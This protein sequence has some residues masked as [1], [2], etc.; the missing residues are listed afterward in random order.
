MNSLTCT[1][2]VCHTRT[3]R[4]Q[5]TG[6]RWENVF[7]GTSPQTIAKTFVTQAEDLMLV[8]DSPGSSTLYYP[9]GKT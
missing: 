6:Y 9:I 5:A 7:R 3:H 4:V 1:E 2:C 8:L